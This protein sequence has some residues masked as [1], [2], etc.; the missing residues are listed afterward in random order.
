ME[1][2]K[3]GHKSGH[4]RGRKGHK[5]THVIP[6]GMLGKSLHKHGG[7]KKAGRKKG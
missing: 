3:V 1:K 5:G 4:K 7:H 6:A 2:H